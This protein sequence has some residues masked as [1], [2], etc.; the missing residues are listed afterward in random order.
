MDQRCIKSKIVWSDNDTHA[1]KRITEV[2]EP[3][4]VATENLSSSSINLLVGEGTLNFLMNEI[5]LLKTQHGLTDILL[6]NFTA[7]LTDHLHTR[8]NKVI[9]SLILY[10]RRKGQCNLLLEKLFPEQEVRNGKRIDRLVEK[11]IYFRSFIL[12]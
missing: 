12:K 7:T 8:R 10:F 11:Y 9:N 2:F 3:A 4:R 5:A 1:L 6:N